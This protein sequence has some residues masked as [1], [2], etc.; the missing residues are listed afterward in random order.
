MWAVLAKEA[1]KTGRDVTVNVLSRA[2]DLCKKETGES[3]WPFIPEKYWEK[4]V[5]EQGISY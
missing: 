1:I 5:R 2:M 3:I 4:A